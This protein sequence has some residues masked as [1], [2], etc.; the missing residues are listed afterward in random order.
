MQRVPMSADERRTLQFTRKELDDVFE[1]LDRDGSGSVELDEFITVRSS[2]L[3]LFSVAVDM[4]VAVAVW[5]LWL[6]GAVELTRVLASPR[7]QRMGMK[8]DGYGHLLSSL[9]F[10]VVV[11]CAWWRPRR[12]WWYLSLSLIMRV[13]RDQT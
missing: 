5:L 10:V 8:D 9:S 6:P 1:L 13:C 7:Q 3:C 2:R 4:G 12:W 11:Q